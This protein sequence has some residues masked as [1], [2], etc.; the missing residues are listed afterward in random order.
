MFGSHTYL[1]LVDTSTC[2][3]LTH[4]LAFVSCVGDFVP[5]VDSKY[6]VFDGRVLNR[7][8]NKPHASL[9]FVRT[10]PN[11]KAI[12]KLRNLGYFPV[13]VLMPN[14][15]K[16]TN[17]TQVLWTYLIVY[18]DA[19]GLTRTHDMAGLVKLYVFYG[20]WMDSRGECWPVLK[21]IHLQ[22][23]NGRRRFAIVAV[24]SFTELFSLLRETPSLVPL[25][26]DSGSEMSPPPE[27]LVAV[28]HGLRRMAKLSIHTM[29]G[30]CMSTPD[31]WKD[32]EQ[33]KKTEVRVTIH[34]ILLARV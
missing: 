8:N 11:K 5:G 9:P 7:R 14:G 17:F 12:K 27:F 10:P 24:E 23:T 26:T 19:E 31:S 1:C 34:C 28:E 30:K 13:Q 16:W 6:H 2:V 33:W 3:L 29:G 15:K 25:L 18:C 20:F 4:V 32:V 21:S 22:T